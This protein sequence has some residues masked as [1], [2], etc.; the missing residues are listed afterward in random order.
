MIPNKHHSITQ[1]HSLT[2]SI[3]QSFSPSV[4]SP[5]SPRYLL[6]SLLVLILAFSACKKNN[7]EPVLTNPSLLIKTATQY[8]DGKVTGTTAYEY[9]NLGRIAKVSY[10]AGRYEKYSYVSNALILKEV[11]NNVINHYTDTLHLNDQGLVI[12]VNQSAAYEYDGEGYLV[13]STVLR[14]KY[15]Y[16]TLNV[17][18]D[19]NIL[20]STSITDSLGHITDISN[21]KYDYNTTPPVSNTIGNE[22]TGMAFW[23][24]NWKNLPSGSHYTYNRNA[25][26]YSIEKD[27]SFMHALDSY[28]RIVKKSQLSSIAEY[29]TIYAYSD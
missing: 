22:N 29:Y 21:Y 28:L 6:L 9:D 17:V 25:D 2:P 15:T 23:G 11:Y 1:N 14:D 24:K 3:L 12:A 18:V 19:G 13:K 5:M 26:K 27:Y 8:Q 20:E 16:L 4:L 7:D 10:N